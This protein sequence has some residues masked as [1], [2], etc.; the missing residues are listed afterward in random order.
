MSS[1][2]QLPTNNSAPRCSVTGLPI[3]SRP[4]WANILLDSEYSVTFSIVGEAIIL[5]TPKGKPSDKGAKLL[6]EKREEVINDAGLFDKKLV[7]L[8]DY[9]MLTAVPSK[10]G[11]MVLTN[12]LLKEQSKGH[13]LGFWVFGAPLLIRFMIRAGLRL[14]KSVIPIDAAKDYEEAIRHALNVLRQNGV[15]AGTNLYSSIKKDE[16]ALDIDD[17][18][19]SFELI[20]EDILYTN[21]RGK[22]KES[23]IDQFFKLNKKVLDE[24][25]LTKKGYY[26]RIVNWERFESSTWKARRMYMEGINEINKKTPCKAAAIFGLNKFMKTLIGISSPFV[27]SPVIAANDLQEALEII[28]RERQRANAGRSAEKKQKHLAKTYTEAQLSEYANEMLQVIGGINWDQEGVSLGDISEE[29][30]LKPVLDALSIIKLDLDNMLHE[31]ESSQKALNDSE[32]MYRFLAENASDTIWMMSLEGVF[33]Y[34]SP[35]IMKLRGYT[36]EE[37]NNINMEQTVTPAS[38]S[39]LLSI[40]DEENAKPMAERWADRALEMEMYRKDGSI[41]WTEASIRAVRDT[42]GNV[43]GLQGST[44]DISDRRKAKSQ[45]EAALEALKESEALF[46]SYLENAPDGIYMSDLEGNF[47]YGNRKCEEIIGYRREELI[48]KNFLELN[49]LPESS[50]KKAV[51]LLQA[52]MDEKSSGPHGIE[53]INQSGRIVPVEITSNIV[54]RQGQIVVLAFVR[55]ITERKLAE[56]K[57]KESE[58]KYRWV[59]DNMA[60]VITV[61]DMNLRFTYVSPSIL[62]LRGYTAEEVAAQTIDQLMTPESLRISIQTFEEYMQLEAAG[63][64]DSEKTIILELEQ[65][66]KDGSTVWVEVSMSLIRDEAQKPTGIISVSRDISERKKAEGKLRKREA[67]Y[68][69]LANNMRDQVWL[70]DL[71]LKPTYISPSVAKAR[72]YTLEEIAQLPLDKH[73]TATSLQVAMEFFAIHMPKALADPSYFLRSSLELEFFRKNGSTYCVETA[74]SLIRD[75]NGKPVSLLGVGRDITDRKQ[76]E[77]KLLKSEEKYRNILQNIED[78]YFEVDLVGNFTFF[79]TS[80]C[81]IIGYPA[82][83]MTGMNN[84]VYM[85]SENAKKVLQSFH[86]IYLTGI[87]TRGVEWE[88]IQKSGVIR[89]LDVSVSLIVNPGEKPA[90]FRGVVRD[91]TERRLL[92]ATQQA[93][94]K[95]ETENKAKSQFLANMSHEIRTPLNGIMGM[96]EAFLD[97]VLDQEQKHIACT[98]TKEA[99]SL[100][101]IINAILDFSKIEAGKLEM[102]RIPFDLRNLFEDVIE[103]FLYRTS[104]K[105]LELI[106]FISPET[107]IRIVGDP[108]R[109]RQILRNLI[110]NAIKFTHK[111]RILV[112]AEAVEESGDGIKLRFMVTDTGIGIP[113]EKQTLVF[114]SFTQADGSTTR[115]YGGTGLGITIS[116]QLAELMGGNLGLE[117]EEGKGSTFW[118]TALFS[119]HGDMEPIKIKDALLDGIRML[120]IDDNKTNREIIVEYIRSWGAVPLEAAS[121]RKALSILR[122]SIDDRSR[123]NLVLIEFNTREMNGFDLARE[124]RREAD[125]RSIP[126]IIITPIGNPGDGKTCSDI[127]IEGYLTK[128]IA[129]KELRKAIE[130][131]LWPKL[132]GESAGET[133]LVTKYT[134][135]EMERKV[136][137]ILLAEDY[138]T[139]QEIAKRHLAQA[140]YQV[141]LA[142]NGKLALDAFKSKH[143]DLILMDVQMPVMDG[144]DATKAI[145]EIEAQ[146]AAMEHGNESQ[147]VQRVPIVAMTA[148]ALQEYKELCIKAG[149]DDFLSKPLTRKDLLAITAKWLNVKSKSATINSISGDGQSISPKTMHTGSPIDLKRAV[150]EFEGDRELLAEVI[151]GFAKKVSEQLV[152]IRKALSCSDAEIVRREA[153]SIKGGAAALT[154][155]DLAKV[156]AALEL[157][158]KSEDLSGADQ[159]VDALESEFEALRRYVKEKY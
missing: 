100:L 88:V 14:N 107:P 141:D 18:G 77:G 87:P 27:S 66:R 155:G 96:A 69:L 93:K 143:Y 64:V 81:R 80:M 119:K 56:E 5:V 62:R 65:Y 52:N 85:D 116:K 68:R 153:H 36:P 140:G 51:Q 84:R 133:H 35:S 45:R 90:G 159:I 146:L 49:L 43:I 151:A 138:P 101:G 9:R 136:I 32:V 24:S 131:V 132:E 95:A 37:A 158:G 25:G 78:G 122:E 86:E 94:L 61:M 34:H 120:V 82:E 74:F 71:N 3:S 126:I 113:K 72:G 105:G 12:F 15:D 79:N 75:E 19:I 33:T 60:D 130:I 8:R 13:L 91:V 44:R 39:F 31:K 128:P 1:S 102:E 103:S 42:E 115:K 54:K 145:R 22:L 48:G 38:V 10:G 89:Y 63:K 67:Q 134:S 76:A 137:R 97:T 144:C 108:G 98:I 16:W 142:E 58:E 139:N 156:A 20:G 57:L 124:I 53:L 4:E 55:D 112:K 157:K 47:L 109:L 73:L 149:M 121:G 11:R 28:E 104:K 59:M 6:L 150:D 41:I 17:Y 147:T 83:E 106:S 123:V 7:E 21:A 129:E 118:F 70:M 114:E 111:G 30:P 92:A 40:L 110:G 148:H 23:N 117:S 46:R 99:D 135:L 154:A 50:L 29:H 125:F 26:Y 127:G 2:D 152:T